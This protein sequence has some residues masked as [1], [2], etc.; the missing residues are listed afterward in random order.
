MVDLCEKS[1]VVVH[2]YEKN[3]GHHNS[4][5]EDDD[6]LPPAGLHARGQEAGDEEPYQ[7]PEEDKVSYEEPKG[8]EVQHGLRADSP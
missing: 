7:R 2:E 4:A 8:H 6:G 3:E 1:C 5:I